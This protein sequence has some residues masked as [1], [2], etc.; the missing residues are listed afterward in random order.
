MF[1]WF[2]HAN[3]NLNS[4]F[5]WPVKMLFIRLQPFVY[6]SCCLDPFLHFLLLCLQSWGSSFEGEAQAEIRLPHRCCDTVCLFSREERSQGRTLGP[7][8]EAKSSLSQT[9]HR[10]QVLH[11][12]RRRGRSLLL[13]PTC[14]AAWRWRGGG[15]GWWRWKESRGRG[16]TVSHATVSTTSPS[17]VYRPFLLRRPLSTSRRSPAVRPRWNASWE[18]RAPAGE[19]E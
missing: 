10:H 11:R 18:T 13:F 5:R 2:K 14:P 15:G 8:A 3:K 17:C 6:S 16:C 9:R 1:G 12:E 7:I 4:T 19:E